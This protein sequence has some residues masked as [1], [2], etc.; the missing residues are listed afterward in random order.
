M[1]LLS[2]LLPRAGHSTTALA[3]PK[4]IARTGAM[5]LAH[6]LHR[7]DDE[8][9]K[10]L[11]RVEQQDNAASHSPSEVSPS[12][13]L[14]RSENEEAQPLH[15]AKDDEA[16]P[17]NRAPEEEA[18]P[19]RRAEDENAAQPLQRAGTDD[20][21]QAMHRAEVEDE[22][23]ALDRTQA[24][25]AT[26]DDLQPLRR[27]E[28]E[29]AQPL[30]RLEEYAQPLA[31]LSPPD[32]QQ[33]TAE[34]GPK[35]ASLSS[36]DD[37]PPAM[38]LR[39]EPVLGPPVAPNAAAMTE[40]GPLPQTDTAP[41]QFEPF[42]HPYT[43]AEPNAPARFDPPQQNPISPEGPAKVVID[44]VDVV[45]HEPTRASAPASPVA[46]LSAMARRRYLGGF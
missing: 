40:A 38:T 31:R 21:E 41:A 13:S 11:H 43:D 9:A 46:D 23:R 37:Q 44:Q 16:E 32:D 24:P 33:L 15:R 35:P 30:H 22:T 20:E 2:R 39:R 6:P 14:S 10:P 8:D 5:D 1:S 36:T 4:G 28:E 3:L 42:E 25:R 12:A 45:I 29:A 19:C 26:D 34:N 18:Q 17:M 7:M 27:S